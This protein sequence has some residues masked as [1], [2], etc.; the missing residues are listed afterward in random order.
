M[1]SIVVMSAVIEMGV[2]RT[3]LLEIVMM[4]LVM[5][6]VARAVMGCS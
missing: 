6:T 2:M 4:K 3:I 5:V 1:T